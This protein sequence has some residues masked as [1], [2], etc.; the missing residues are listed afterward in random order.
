MQAS[1][2]K[3]L[4]VS[5]FCG[6]LVAVANPA[7][8]EDAVTLKIMK[9]ARANITKAKTSGGGFVPAE[10]AEELKTPII[11]VS[12]AEAVIE[13][14]HRSAIALWCKMDWEKLSYQPLMLAERANKSRTGKQIAYIGLLHGVSMGLTEKVLRK[15]GA[16]S[17]TQRQNLQAFLRQELTQ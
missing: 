4:L 6:L 3:A 11:P 13:I 16:C 17:D 8:A 14:G 10:T 2:Y 5:L 7:A 1:M 12:E 15:Q 9:I